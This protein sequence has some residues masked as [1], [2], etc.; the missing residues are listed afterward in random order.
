MSTK[1]GSS[2]KRRWYS[3]T[4]NNKHSERDKTYQ[5]GDQDKK[6]MLVQSRKKMF[7]ATGLKARTAWSTLFKLNWADNSSS[8]LCTGQ[9]TKTQKTMYT[10]SNS[11]IILRRK[12]NR[13]SLVYLTW[14]I[15]KNKDYNSDIYSVGQIHLH[16][17]IKWYFMIQQF[18]MKEYIQ[19]NLVPK[20]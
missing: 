8:K 1:F 9:A 3:K 13:W 16:N 2:N 12:P 20:L 11:E 6:W 10:A 5:P 7:S 18:Q 14:N 17:E 4:W 15:V 19:K